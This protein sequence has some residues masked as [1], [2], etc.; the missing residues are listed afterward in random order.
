MTTI[1]QIKERWPLNSMLARCGIHAPSKGKFR[2][3][4]RHDNNPSCEIYGEVIKDRSTG[5]SWDSI[6]I[7]AEANKLSN[8]E[9]IK[10]LAAELPSRAPK[11]VPL[12]KMFVLPAL[13]YSPEAADRLCVLRGFS[14][15]SVDFAAITIGS[16]GFG[17]VLGFECWILH[18]GRCIAEARR[19]DGKKFPVAGNLGERKSHTIAGSK[20]SFPIGLN[21]RHGLK[22]LS[23]LPIILVEGGPDYLAACNVSWFMEELGHP[24]LPV[25]MLGASQ[26]INAL[27]L[28][29]FKGRRVLIV[30]QPDDAGLKAS[31][32]WGRQL[33]LAGASPRIRKLDGGDL[34]DLLRTHGAEALAHSLLK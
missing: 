25:A 6:M 15:E 22:A 20:K 30:S 2:S 23:T 11:V 4:F 31:Q 21:P 19:L 26:G 32:N 34:N 1:D 12:E 5:E 33:N 13:H 3:P 17:E 24:H 7:F 27:S 29:F 18:D 8:A 10:R 16:L 14:R 28:P 9:A